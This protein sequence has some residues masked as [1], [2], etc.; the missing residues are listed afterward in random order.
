VSILHL[1]VHFLLQ[2]FQLEWGWA[3]LGGLVAA[4]SMVFEGD[5]GRPWLGQ[6]ASLAFGLLGALVVRIHPV[7]IG[8]VIYYFGSMMNAVQQR[9]KA[10]ELLD[11]DTLVN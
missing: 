8:V 2:P 1:A 6:F 3:S 9:L 10:V 4:G 5:S 7:L 11:D